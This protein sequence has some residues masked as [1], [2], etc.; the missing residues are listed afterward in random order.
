VPAE[1]L[2]LGAVGLV[3]V[4]D[5]VGVA[6]HEDGD[7]GDVHAA[8]G[9]DLAGLG[10]AGGEVA[11]E[12][13]GL[14]GVE[15]EGLDVLELDR[16]AVGVLGGGVDDGEVGALVGLGGGAGGGGE[17]EADRDDQVAALGDHV[18]DVRGEVG[19]GGGLGGLLLD[20]EVLL[21]VQQAVEAGLV[22]GLV[23]PAAGVRV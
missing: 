14:G 13:R 20:A 11:G 16:V 7:G 15:L 23:V 4:G 5:A 21:G 12:E 22:E 1:H 10:H 9:G 19:V 2:D 3:V 6:V 17:E 18:V 8:V